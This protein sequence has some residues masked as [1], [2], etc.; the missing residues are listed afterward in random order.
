MEK[1]KI[2]DE[3]KKALGPM[4][5]VISMSKSGYGDRNPGH[6]AVFNANIIAIDPVTRDAEKVWFGDIDLTVDEDALMKAAEAC[7]VELR[8]LYEM[9]ARFEHE[10]KPLIEK[11]I[12]K[13]P[14]QDFEIGPRYRDYYRRNEDARLV[15]RDSK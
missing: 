15:R 11:Y 9:D 8:V 10:G 14:A 5:R 3:I 12:Y 4:G 1:N 7:D 2:Y 13:Y 6:V